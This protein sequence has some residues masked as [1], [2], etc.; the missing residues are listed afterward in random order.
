VGQVPNHGKAL[1]ENIRKN[2][3]EHRAWVGR[4]LRGAEEWGWAC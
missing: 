1:T 2:Q 3:N 4:D